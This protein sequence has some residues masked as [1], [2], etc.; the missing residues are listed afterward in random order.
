ML[1]GLVFYS[2]IGIICSGKS[3]SE[4][5]THLVDS[6]PTN[7]EMGRKSGFYDIVNKHARSLPGNEGA[8]Q[9][10]S[11][12]RVRFAWLK[13]ISDQVFF[14]QISLSRQKAVGPHR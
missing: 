8:C 1:I 12:N 10:E 2:H 9:D 14:L 11:G 13:L 5:S 7:G 6:S 3:W 4:L